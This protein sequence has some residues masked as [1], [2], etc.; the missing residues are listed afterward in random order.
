M[1]VSARRSVVLQKCW[2]AI[3]NFHFQF[4]PAA[5]LKVNFSAKQINAAGSLEP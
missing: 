3:L 1:F 4:R 2:R 5:I